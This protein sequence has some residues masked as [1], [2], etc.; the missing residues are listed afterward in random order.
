VSPADAIIAAA[1]VRAQKAYMRGYGAALCGAPCLDS[2]EYPQ[3]VPH[4][5]EGYRAGQSVV[6]ADRIARAL[7][8]K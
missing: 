5:L 8:V 4:Y 1:E 7:G 2:A 3:H 6:Q